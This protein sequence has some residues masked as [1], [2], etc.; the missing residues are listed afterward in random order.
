[1]PRPGPRTTVWIVAVL[2]VLA[3][4]PGLMWPLRP[5]EAGFLLV[6]R[7]WDPRPDSMFGTYWVDRSPL[8]IAVVRWADAVGGPFLLRGV[9]AAGCFALVL[10]AASVTRRMLVHVAGDGMT[11]E[12]RA[13]GERAAV[14]VAVLAAA[15]SAN[16]LSDSVSAKGEV[17]GIPVVLA[18]CWAALVA[19]ERRSLAWSG[20]AGLAAAVAVGLKQS[21]LGGLVFGGVLLVGALVARRIDVVVLTRLAGAAVVGASVPVLAT[22]GWAIAAGV[23]LSTVWYAVVDFRADATRVLAE[24]PTAANE[25][26]ARDLLHVAGVG[27][28]AAAVAWFVLNLPRTL[29]RLPVPAVAVLAMLLADLLG[30]VLGGSY[31]RPYLVAVVPSVVLALAVVLLADVRTPGTGRTRRAL[32][33]VPPL[34]ATAAAVSTLFHLVEWTRGTATHDMPTEFYTGEAIGRAAAPGDT[35]VVYGGRAD[36]QWGS[37][38]PSPYEHLWSLP[39]RTLDPDLEQLEALLRGPAAPTW[40]VTWVPMESWGLPAHKVERVLEQRYVLAGKGCGSEG[41]YRLAD[42][43]R[44]PLTTTCDEPYD[45]LLDDV[46]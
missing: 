17:L 46:G 9:A 28:T 41:I 21:L 15:L 14:W 16:P 22:V 33:A 45:R 2:A 43:E 3:R 32:R 8:V 40:V 12:L 27:G 42:A 19:L 36:L 11:E 1:M 10:L 37:G 31:W 39:M 5:D 44:P 26:R 25:E 38:L 29:R 30:V 18:S 34:V 23:D 7:E 35:L 6:A 24:Q 4:Y 13:R 20:A